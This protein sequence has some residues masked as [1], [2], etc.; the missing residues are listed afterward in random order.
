MTIIIL[1]LSDIHIKSSS[2]PV[3]SKAKEIAQ[4]TFQKL[5]N[6][7]KLFIIIS[8]DIA[9]SGTKEQYALAKK[10]LEDIQ[11]EIEVEKE[12][13]ISFIMAPGN[14]DCDFSRDNCTRKII[15]KSLKTDSSPE[16]DETVIETCTEV[17]K[18]FF[19]FRKDVEANEFVNDD[20]LVREATIDVDGTKINFVSLN[21]S[22]LSEIHEQQSLYFPVGNYE[23]LLSEKY[24][25]DIVIL[26]HP[27]NWFN[28]SSY[29]PFREFV[30]KKGDIVISGHEHFG[31]VGLINDTETGESAFV[32][33]CVLQEG[34]SLNESSFNII[35][36]DLESSQFSSTKYRSE[37]SRF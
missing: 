4:C 18:H 25:L 16:V 9:F 26:H 31:N 34:S 2:D 36:I 10:F 22:W 12:I 28:Q 5:H 32:E 7:S 23:H 17:Q 8:G 24:D 20:Q 29:R 15:I 35:E 1:H 37:V 11:I 33:G 27:L 13:S 21:V 14:H 30:K 6:S 3:L 19:E